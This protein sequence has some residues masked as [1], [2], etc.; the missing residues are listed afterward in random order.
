VRII[1]R[2]IKKNGLVEKWRLYRSN[3][4]R[5]YPQNYY[6]AMSLCKGELVFLADQDDI[7]NPQKIQYMSQILKKHKEIHLLCCK[8]SLI[9]E[10]GQVIKAVMQPVVSKET[11][12]ISE[13][14]LKRF[15]KKCEW[16]GM[17][18]AY[19]RSWYEKKCFK[20]HSGIMLPHD[21]LL[22]V[23]AAEENAFWQLDKELAY[24]RRHEKNTGKEEYKINKL[25]QKRKKMWE[26]EKYL[27]DLA[28]VE[29][30]ELPFTEEGR[31]ICQEKKII[32]QNRYVALRSG[33]LGSVLKNAW[34]NRK[35]IRLATVICDLLIVHDRT[36]NG[37]S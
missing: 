13:V 6:Y 29:K 17:V 37:E 31:Q 9:D 28:E 11:G 12:K 34:I 33:S 3:E 8:F 18:L 20:V 27:S 16:P 19:R 22:G 7:W 35:Q 25:L 15:F 26:I 23:W 21:F 30:E 36:G 24:H 32:M 2:F 10:M 4:N 5:G 1:E 14:T